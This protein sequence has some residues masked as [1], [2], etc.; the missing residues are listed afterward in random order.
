M[1]LEEGEGEG[2]EGWRRLSPPKG[3][4]EEEGLQEE[5][6]EEDPEI[7]LRGEM[8]GPEEAGHGDEGEGK[9]EHERQ[10]PL[11]VHPQEAE[12]PSLRFLPI[13]NEED[14]KD[15]EGDGDIEPEGIGI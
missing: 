11:P 14:E 5:P 4:E 13:K 3:K 6:E 7:S 15:E 10:E 2:D 12:D 9:D 8:E 1:F